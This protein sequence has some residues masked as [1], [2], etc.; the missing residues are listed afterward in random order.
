M[1]CQTT[2]TEVHIEP[3][4]PA[5]QAH[6]GTCAACAMYAE[7][8]TRLDRMIRTELVVAAPTVVT[9]QL[10]LAVA[11]PEPTRLEAALRGA[12]LVQAPP[13]LTARLLDLVPRPAPVASPVDALVRDALL[14]QA[15]SA[16][17][18]RLLDLVP[19]MTAPAPVV[20]VAQPLPVAQPQPRRWVVATVYFVTAALLLFSMFYAGQIYGMVVAQLGLEAWLTEVA[21]LPAQLLNQLYTLVPQSRIVVGALVRLQQPLQW[22]L[23]TLV[24][25]AIVDMT[26]RQNQRAR[27]YA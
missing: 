14:V 4:A 10:E 9:H 8:F 24:L 13:A 21:S 2:R 17:T 11:Q 12:V 22:L 5:V 16:L 19:Q 3:A 25:W 6:L 18:A 20:P 27:Q 23:M 7:R 1:D 15:P 26:Q